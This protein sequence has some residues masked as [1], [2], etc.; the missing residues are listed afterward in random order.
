MYRGEAANHGIL[1]AYRLS[2]ALEAVYHQGKDLKQAI[3]EYEM[4][5]R[6]RTNVAVLLSRQACLD[7]HDWDGLNENSAVLKKRAIAG[8]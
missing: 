4:E 2:K 7:A 6:E 8:V 3:D 5:L 1:D